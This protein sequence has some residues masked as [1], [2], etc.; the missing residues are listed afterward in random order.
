[1]H[2]AVTGVQ[3]GEILELNSGESVSQPSSALVV[4]G[5]PIGQHRVLV[6]LVNFQDKQTQPFTREQAQTIMFGTTNNFYREASYGQTWLSGDVYGWYTIPVS[7]AICDTTA[8][9]NSAQQ[10]AAGA[11]ANLASYDHLVY[12]FPQN[13][14][15]WQGR[16]SVGGSPSQAWV[17]EWFEL[18]IVGHELGHNFGLYHS[19][20]MDCGSLSIG[21]NCTTDEYGD[22]MDL[23]GGANSAH[24]NLFQKERLG[25]VNNGSNPPITTVTS[26][27]SYWI[28]SYAT[29]T[30]NPKGLKILKSID[31]VTGAKT[32]YYVEYRIP[33]GFDSFL[34]GNQNVLNG[35]LIRTGA[36]S[37]GQATYLLDM[38]PATTSWYD[39]ALTVGQT[40]AD[41]DAGVT[42]TIVSVGATGAIVDVAVSSQPCVR[43]NPTLTL[44][45]SQSPWMAAGA[46][47][48]FNVSLRNN[49]S[50]GCN[51][52]L[53][54]W[55]VIAPS[56]WVSGFASPT[57]TIGSGATGTT[58][59]QVTSPIGTIDG[60]Y[61]IN[62]NASNGS[63]P[64]YVGNAP[65]TYVLVSGLSVTSTATQATYTRSQIAT[66]NATIKAAGTIVP[67]AAVTFMMTKSNGTIV[68]SNATAGSN[69]VAVFKYSFNRKKDP[70]GTYQVRAQATANGVS[71]S[72]TVSLN[73][74]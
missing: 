44:A 74:K 68:T 42:I 59:L 62:V 71:G 3:V 22:I 45:P 56:A 72:G 33:Y 18:G 20:S 5:N 24:F 50:T 41:A 1:M 36:D 9:A 54:N 13:A 48:T 19:R 21:T 27:G 53:F 23:M 39:P 30:L 58:T 69:G 31:A 29:G 8:I 67:G 47:A 37:S 12:A 34:S 63:N 46:T 52:A 60:F 64:S 16:G 70:A 55:Q 28:D 40:F 35:V 32:W 61:A 6:I 38:T 11:G 73:V 66:V 57:V 17:N 25:W 7:S 14:C 51:P 4:S 43:A 26:S 65:A 2:V 10:A 15:T 49:D